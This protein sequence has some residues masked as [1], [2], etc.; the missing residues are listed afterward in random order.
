MHITV[1]ALLYDGQR[2]IQEFF[3]AISVS[4]LQV[5]FTAL[6]FTPTGTEL[7]NTYHKQM[8]GVVMVQGALPTQWGACIQVIEGH[9]HVVRSVSFSPDGTRIVSGPDDKT[10]KVWDA[11]TGAHLQTLEGHSDKVK[12]V[13]FSPDGTRIVSG[14]DDG[15]VKVWDVGTGVLQ[16]IHSDSN[17]G[18]SWPYLINNGWLS[19]SF[20]RHNL[21]WIPV[22]YR[23]I[24]ASTID[25]MAVVTYQ[26]SIIVLQFTA[27][28]SYLYTQFQLPL[29]SYIS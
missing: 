8:E 29:P 12:S 17:F 1:S 7:Y 4:A 14:S 28:H 18:M 3:P 10:V 25:Q 22:A 27:L 15:T 5:Y 13:S 6:P 21:C 2:L 23:N 11:V 19:T 26:D 24:Y 16:T 9:S 20:T